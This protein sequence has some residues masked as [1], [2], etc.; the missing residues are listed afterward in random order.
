MTAT[1]LPLPGA[2]LPYAQEHLRLKSCTTR[3]ALHD[4]ERAR[5]PPPA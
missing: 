3:V 2:A 1:L 5:G 4:L